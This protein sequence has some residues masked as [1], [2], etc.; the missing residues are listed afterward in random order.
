[1]RISSRGVRDALRRGM[2]MSAWRV[3]YLSMRALKVLNGYEKGARDYATTGL[4]KE[5]LAVSTVRFFLP[6]LKL[7]MTI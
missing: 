6:L 5:R 7:V 1:M 2:M 4:R 3:G